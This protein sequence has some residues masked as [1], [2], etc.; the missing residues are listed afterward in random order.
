MSFVKLKTK[1]KSKLQGISSIQEVADYPN[2]EFNGY[3]AVTI[4]SA[5]NEG[6]FETTTENKRTYVFKVFVLQKC[7]NEIGEQKARNI[8]D[9]VVDDIIETFDEDQLLSGIQSTLPT[10]ETMIISF[11]ALGEVR[12]EPPYV[13]AELEIKVII[14]F[15]TT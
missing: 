2:D 13:V 12:N 6:E 1:I 14:S 7:D 9:E 5:R 15:S 3:P 4:T 8:V 10:Q 11:P